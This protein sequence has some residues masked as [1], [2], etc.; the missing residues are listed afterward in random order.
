M[1]YLGLMYI[2]DGYYLLS[3]PDGVMDGCHGRRQN[4]TARHVSA[5]IFEFERAHT[6]KQSLAMLNLKSTLNLE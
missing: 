1:W 4:P 3:T 2:A 5:V 6:F